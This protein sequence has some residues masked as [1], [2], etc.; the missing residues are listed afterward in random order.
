MSTIPDDPDAPQEYAADAPQDGSVWT[1]LRR[2]HEQ[3]ASAREP[4]ELDVPGYSGLRIRF[5][6]VPLADT[7]SRA[8]ALSKVR[9]V[10]AQALY[11]CM[12]T[13]IMACD[14]FRVLRPDDPRADKGYA[15]LAE[16]GQPP[17]RFD[18]VLAEGL[19]LPKHNE[20]SARQVVHHVF[21][22]EQGHYLIM[23]MARQVSEWMAS[24]REDV[25]DEFSGKSQRVAR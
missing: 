22:G 4:L 13:L 25:S 18:R 21:G 16:P 10:T 12:D 9:E 24:T 2:E 1:Q 7:E 6:F 17:I 11:G 14:E 20:L 3:L 8:K 5:K 23:E 19:G 15:P